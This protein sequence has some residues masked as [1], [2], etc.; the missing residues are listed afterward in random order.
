MKYLIVLIVTFLIVLF[1]AYGLYQI[2]PSVLQNN[3]NVSNLLYGCLITSFAITGML[4]RDTKTIFRNM[5]Q[6]GV[7]IVIILV[8]IGC[9]GLRYQIK[10]FYN[11]I[12]QNLVPAKVSN[13]QNGVVSVAKS[14]NGHYMLIAQINSQSVYFL[15]DTGATDVSLT[16][17][18]A[19]RIG[20]NPDNLVYN[21]ASNTANGI[22]Y[23]AKITIPSI[24][25]GD[26]TINNVRASVVKQGLDTS[27][28]GMSFLS[29]LTSYSATND[30]LIMTKK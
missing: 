10:D 5:G 11:V 20:I 17:A 27:L 2:N 14:S 3:D 25:I 26:I 21:Q 23:G 24:T 8:L 6:L 29:K 1:G 7:W 16:A 15:V 9:Y 12:M 18:D 19:R 4:S 13:L 28:L 22:N 30:V